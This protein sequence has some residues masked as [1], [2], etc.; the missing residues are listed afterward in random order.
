M[1]R[2]TVDEL[3]AATNKAISLLVRRRIEQGLC[4][5]CGERGRLDA[6]GGARCTIHG[7][8]VLQIIPPAADRTE[9]WMCE[10]D[11]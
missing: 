6:S 3:A 2:A 1:G 8:Y 4:P 10:E 9:D 7:V 11:P 5:Q